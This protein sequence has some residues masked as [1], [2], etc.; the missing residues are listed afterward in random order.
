MKYNNLL[1]DID[2]TI[3]GTNNSLVGHNPKLTS[4]LNEYMKR[5][6]IIGLVTG[7]NEVYSSAVYE[8]F[9]LNGPK[10]VEKGAG[11]IIPDNKIIKLNELQQKNEIKLL[12]QEL[13]IYKIMKNEPKEFMIS[14][15]LFDFPFHDPKKIE[16]I[17]NKI[18]PKIKEKFQ[19]IE[20]TFDRHSI[21][22]TNP[23]ADKGEAIKVYSQKTQI[24]LENF[25]IIGDSMG[26][27]PGFKIIG[28]AGGLVGYVG[29]D[30]EVE[31]EVRKFKNHYISKEKRS[32][33][34]VEIMNHSLI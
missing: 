12:L 16:E 24:S 31:K 21:D 9:G 29:F 2:G 26:D 15:L 1:L 22:I 18:S 4:T 14:L 34:L 13:G 20:V 3:V 8:I 7:R 11:I 30:K 32:N 5:G 6:G 25:T 19:N 33:G 17:Y 28:E 10:I 27:F 23:K